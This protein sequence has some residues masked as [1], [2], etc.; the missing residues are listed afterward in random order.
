MRACSRSQDRAGR[1]AAGPD[2]RSSEAQH[3][4]GMQ[5]SGDTSAGERASFA[6]PLRAREAWNPPRVPRSADGPAPPAR[7]RGGLLE[8]ALR[9]WPTIGNARALVRLSGSRSL[10]PQANHR[11]NQQN[12][13]RK[14]RWPAAHRTTGW[15]QRTRRVAL[16]RNANIAGIRARSRTTG[17][18]CTVSRER[19]SV[20]ALENHP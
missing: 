6:R 7:R 9:A 16:R 2:A 5:A 4:G 11:Y 8:H 14:R 1:S 12:N 19:A 18:A 17:T 20:A 13:S 15:Q 3:T 10:A